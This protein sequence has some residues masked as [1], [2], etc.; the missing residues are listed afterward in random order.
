MNKAMLFIF[1]S[2]LLGVNVNC[3]WFFFLSRLNELFCLLTAKGLFRQCFF[4]VVIVFGLIL[5]L[6]NNSSLT[7][8]YNSVGK[9][10]PVVFRMRS[11]IF[12]DKQTPLSYYQTFDDIIT[13][14]TTKLLFSS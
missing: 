5:G 3:L 1:F 14:I 10:R 2:G 4:I 9:A 12:Q 13:D 7:F 11:F 6:G 8:Y